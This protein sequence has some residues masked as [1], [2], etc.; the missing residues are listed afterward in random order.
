M[1]RGETPLQPPL[2]MDSGKR[3]Q[4]ACRGHAAA[5]ESCR[6]AQSSL[7]TWSALRPFLRLIVRGISV[8]TQLESCVLPLTDCRQRGARCPPRKMDK[9][10]AGP[11]C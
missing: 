9:I 5:P 4:G 3:E 7:D 8:A 1:E 11:I 10:G 2:G 6:N